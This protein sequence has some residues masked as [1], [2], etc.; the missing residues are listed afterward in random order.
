MTPESVLAREFHFPVGVTILDDAA[1]SAAGLGRSLVLRIFSS[2][3]A[4][5]R[6]IAEIVGRIPELLLALDKRASGEGL[7]RL[8][9]LMPQRDDALSRAAEALAE[10]LVRYGAGHLAA[11]PVQVNLLRH[12]PTP[13][14]SRR[15][16]D[17]VRALF[18]G[19]L[20][21][22]RGQ[23]FVLRDLEGASP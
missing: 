5:R 12:P 16:A 21:G 9:V 4:D 18:G 6:A 1:Q 22:V 14:G 15:A 11:R 10:T 13:E 7:G 19:R 8:C 23:V 2:P 17:M 3:P 20:D